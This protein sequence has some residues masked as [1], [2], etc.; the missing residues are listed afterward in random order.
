MGLNNL[1]NFKNP[2]KHFINIDLLTFP[3]AISSLE[4]D[5]L[6]WTKPFTFRIRK[7]HDKHRSLKIPNILN[8]VV[9]YEHFKTLPNFESIQD[10]DP[11]HKRLSANI[12]TGDFISGEYDRQLEEDFEKLSIY[13]HLVK[14]D[15]KEYYGRIYTHY[16]NIPDPYKEGYLTNMNL[17]GTNGLIMGNY[18][19]LFFAELNLL[20]ISR[21]IEY[22]IEK[23]AIDCKFSYFSDDFYFFCNKWDID[24]IIKVFDMVLDKYG[25]ERNEDKKDIWTY[26]T[27]NNNNLV[28]RYWKKII[29]YCNKEFKEDRNDNK[30][31]FINQIIYRISQLDDDM[32]KKVLINSFFKTKYFREL[33]LE[34]YKVKN[35]DYHQLCFLFKYSP[36]SLLYSIDKFNEMT[37]FDKDKVFE[38]F[39]VRYIETL[40]S[41]FNDEQL[42]F[43]YAI[44]NLGFTTILSEAKD[45][46][47]GTDNQI[48][49]SYYLQENLL[50]EDDINIL[51]AKDDEL[52]WFQNYHLILYSDELKQNMEDSIS[53]YLIP[54]K[55]TKEKQRKEYLKFYKE[56]LGRGIAIIRDIVDVNE[57]IK[58]YLGLKVEESEAIYEASR[59][60]IDDEEDF[61]S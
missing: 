36:E 28:A 45:W 26:E 46:V 60:N 25:L 18:L 15:I 6:S 2:I 44:K 11:L 7:K 29:A 61:L 35:Y 9:A 31:Y 5:S 54:K 10:I 3:S 55:A 30:L 24:E 33:D 12:D 39:R 27:F 21:D 34:K 8:F 51:K 49:I 23:L 17:G 14:V 20:D 42:Y 13:D 56:N 50:N 37:G 47:L 22:K 41:Q 58:Y 52:Y 43:Y 38:F 59:V 48:L 19:S 1:Y 16:L 32:H 4:L 40:K 57:E 53:R